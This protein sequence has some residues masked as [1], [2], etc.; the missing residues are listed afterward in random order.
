MEQQEIIKLAE[1]DRKGG[2][3][4]LEAFANRR[5]YRGGISL[6]NITDQE[7]SNL[8]WAANGR[9][10]PDGLRTAPSALNA[11][12]IDVY[13][14]MAQGAYK[15]DAAKHEL[16]LI[17]SGDYRKAAGGGQDF[18]ADVPVVLVLAAD[19]AKYEGAAAHMGFD[20]STMVPGMAAM[21]AGIVS[22]NI[23]LFCAGSGLATITR[24]L[25]DQ[26]VLKEALKLKDSQHLLLNNAVGY[27]EE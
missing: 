22:Q 24:G 25:M 17:S 23:N 16:V 11:Q 8:L 18:V 14:I 21:D 13:A 3:T 12:D 2:L 6:K 19:Y 7:L 5:A 1:P 27:P 10:R 15:Y 20:M 26:I 9:N 4:V